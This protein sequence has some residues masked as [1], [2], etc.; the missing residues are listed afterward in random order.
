MKKRFAIGLDAGLHTGLA[1]YD[2]AER[3]ITEMFK[4]DFWSAYEFITKNFS[5][6]IALIVIERPRKGF[7]YSRNQQYKKSVVEKI[8]FNSGENNREATL[9]IEGFEYLGYEVRKVTP[10]ASKWTAEQLKRFTGISSRTNEH[11]RDAVRL[12]WQR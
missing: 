12:V 1:V 2:R 10:V 11:V 9:L 5:P 8:A 3:R 6:D 7:V 4:T